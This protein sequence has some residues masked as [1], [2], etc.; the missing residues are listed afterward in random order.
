MPPDK[1]ADRFYTA[2]L[3]ADWDTAAQLV[4]DDLTVVEAPGLPFGGTYHGIAG[5]KSLVRSVFANFQHLKVTP[6]SITANHN[7]AAVLIRAEGLG[8]TTGK[9]FDTLICEWLTF[10]DNRIATISPFYWDQ[11]LINTL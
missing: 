4:T 2:L 5:L 6:M 3:N 9:P 11:Q 1:C 10:R 7:N 8:L